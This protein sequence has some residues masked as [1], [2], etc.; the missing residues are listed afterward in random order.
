IDDNHFPSHVAWSPKGDSFVVF[1]TT[2]FSRH[3]LPLLFKHKNFQS[4]VRQLNKYGF[5]KV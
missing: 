3:V 5:S 2:E 1:D 4:F